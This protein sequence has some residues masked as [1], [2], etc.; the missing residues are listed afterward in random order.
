MVVVKGKRLLN[1]G[2][3]MSVQQVREA[4]SAAATGL[5]ATNGDVT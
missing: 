3:D 1:D 5:S 2:K 4:A